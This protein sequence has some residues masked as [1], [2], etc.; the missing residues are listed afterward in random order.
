VDF[1]CCIRSK[2]DAG[3]TDK[4]LEAAINNAMRTVLFILMFNCLDP[5]RG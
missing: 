2:P 5:L 1:S 3:L 4:R